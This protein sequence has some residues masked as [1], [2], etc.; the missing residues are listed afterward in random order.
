MFIVGDTIV[1]EDFADHCFVC[2]LE[3]CHGACCVQGDAGAPL[4]KDELEILDRIL[5]DIEPFLTKQGKEAIMQ[6]GAWIKSG[7]EEF[8]TPLSNSLEC[9]YAYFSNGY[10][11][12]AIEQAW[13]LKLIDFRKPL[14]CHLY[15][16]RLSEFKDFTAVNYHQW[17][18]CINAIEKGEKDG[19]KLYEFLKE[20]LIRKFG[21]EWYNDLVESVKNGNR[22]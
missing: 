17:H 2:D 6:Y 12:C 22:K 9:A 1:S 21:K 18:I 15:P 4:N 13:M 14:S 3:K 20:P 10:V 8:G 5:P 11:Q 16:A 19:V 7:D